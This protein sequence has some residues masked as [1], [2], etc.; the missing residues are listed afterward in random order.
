MTEPHRPTGWGGDGNLAIW[1][2]LAAAGVSAL[3]SGSLFRAAVSTGQAPLRMAA[4]LLL[5]A[6][7][8]WLAAA[9]ERWQIRE[10]LR[11]LERVID[12]LPDG[13]EAR[14]FGVRAARR[15]GWVQGYLLTGP[16]G[17]M[18]LAAL[19]LSQATWAPLARRILEARGMSL[20]AAVRDL[21][22]RVPALARRSSEVGGGPPVAV[23]AVAVLLRRRVTRAERE[24]LGRLHVGAYNVEELARA[25]DAVRSVPPT[26]A[27][28]L[29]GNVRA[30]VQE[31][32]AKL[33]SVR[34]VRPARDVVGQLS[35]RA[36]G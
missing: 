14:R 31:A 30:A 17:V 24:V 33:W 29:S 12:R 35:P 26:G 6:A 22:G 23:Y 21:R 2:Q 27:A 4:T 19:G 10:A 36:E 20:R 7:G 3:L 28:A 25:V 32:A 34:P 18:V 11:A 16:A 13:V 1:G 15:Y 8:L 9:A 5:V